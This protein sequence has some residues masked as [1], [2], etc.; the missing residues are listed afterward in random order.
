MQIASLDRFGARL[1]VF[2]LSAGISKQGIE[3]FTAYL[4]RAFDHFEKYA[5]DGNNEAPRI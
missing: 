2:G 5:P 4:D 3:P 1:R